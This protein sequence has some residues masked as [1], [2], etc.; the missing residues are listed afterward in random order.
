[1]SLS[2]SCHRAFTAKPG[3][4]RRIWLCATI[5]SQRQEVL[6]EAHWKWFLV[7]SY[8]NQF[9]LCLVLKF[10]LRLKG[11]S[12]PAPSQPKLV[13]PESSSVKK[14][15]GELRLAPEVALAR[16][17]VVATPQEVPAEPSRASVTPSPTSPAD[18]A[19]VAVGGPKSSE[20]TSPDTV[21]FEPTCR[22]PA[23]ESGMEAPG[24]RHNKACKKRFSEF[25]E[26]RRKERRV[27]PGLRALL[28]FPG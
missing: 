25:E 5:I 2:G 4:K 9:A 16:P 23:C 6:T 1:M 11:Q 18:T 15:S 21:R 26:Q 3:K 14:K 19:D 8:P 13:L 12:L 10:L 22:C 20:R 27:E 24:I 28:L 17:K 7:G